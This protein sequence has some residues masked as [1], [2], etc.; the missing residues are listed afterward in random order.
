[1]KY[2]LAKTDPETYGIKD[3]E[4]E[5]ITT[6]NGVKNPTAVA[7]LKK[8]EK[9]DKVLIYHS[10]GEAAIVGLAEV[11]GNS[12]PDPKEPRSWLVDFKYLKSYKEPFV[13][14]KQI[15]ETG[16]FSDFKLV[17]ISRL[18]TMDVPEEFIT[19]LKKQGVAV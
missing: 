8:M 4:K 16:K 19:W 18:S 15:K 3:L 10:Q 5:G 13:T 14:L 7:F 12:R 11:V 1:M 17:R 2:Y 6:W 9:G